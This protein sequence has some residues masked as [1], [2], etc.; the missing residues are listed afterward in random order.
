M[1]FE[2][3]WGC[4]STRCDW[5]IGLEKIRKQE[6]SGVY[7]WVEAGGVFGIEIPG[8]GLYGEGYRLWIHFGHIK[9]AVSFRHSSGHVI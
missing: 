4:I 3:Y 5:F 1:R 8:T 9:C 6:V 2:N 7:N